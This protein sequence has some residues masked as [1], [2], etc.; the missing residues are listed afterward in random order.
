MQ[1]VKLITGYK[2]CIEKVTCLYIC[3]Y[4]WIFETVRYE[5][6]GSSCNADKALDIC[7]APVKAFYVCTCPVGK[8]LN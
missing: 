4:L 2:L 1:L 6:I 5:M 3:L 8:I 7:H